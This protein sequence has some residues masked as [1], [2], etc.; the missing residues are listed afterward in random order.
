MYSFSMAGKKSGVMER[1]YLP[2]K[3]RLFRGLFFAALTMIASQVFSIEKASNR[4][5]LYEIRLKNRQFKPTSKQLASYKAAGDRP[6]KPGA[7]TGH[8]IL[9]FEEKV[10]NQDLNQLRQTGIQIVEWI[11]RNAVM[12][13]V[14]ES[15]DITSIENIRWA[16]KMLP[17]D[18]ISRHVNQSLDKDFFLVDFFGD[19]KI[20]K[21]L[22]VII[23]CGGRIVNNPY[24]VKRTFLVN[25]DKQV[26][27]KLSETEQVSWLWPASDAVIHCEPVHRCAGAL[28]EHGIVI[29]N[30]VTESEGWDGPGQ[31]SVD[32]DY[33]FVNGTT[34]ISGNAEE[35][36]VIRAF[37]EWS[38][39]AEIAWSQTYNINKSTRRRCIDVLWATGDH[40]DGLP[41]DDGGDSDGNVL[42]HCF[43]P[44]TSYEYS[45]TIFGDLHFDDYE[46]WRIGANFDIFS[47]ALHECGHGLGIGHSDDSGAVMYAYYRI[48]DGLEQDDIDAVRSIYK[49][50]GCCSINVS[51]PYSASIWK[52]GTTHQISW[53]SD[54]MDGQNVSI[55]LY[56]EDSFDSAITYNTGND[57]SFQWTLP[58]HLEGACNWRVKISSVSDSSCHDYSDV[59]CIDPLK[60]ADVDGD[61]KVNGPD[62]AIVSKHWRQTNCSD[63]PPCAG[64]DLTGDKNVDTQDLIEMAE[65]W[66]E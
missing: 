11:P 1:E 32:L 34:D 3:L 58:V 14:P 33:Y 15:V 17:A 43:Y 41:F 40:G 16:G 28:T 9:Q 52:A 42:A 8:V 6:D 12:A 47:V 4:N 50:A 10:T 46:T 44:A 61:N 25:G 57:G 38:K 20:D 24:L 2:V 66:L 54:C 30:Y 5:N 31:G 49:P 59:F 63:T 13:G 65:N 56:L 26:L 22:S 7:L 23:S 51:S 27:D 45:N 39:Y 35:S 21:A 37:H 29:G 64:A 53:T 62:F 36:E 55:D 48:A 60:P 19:V 18:K